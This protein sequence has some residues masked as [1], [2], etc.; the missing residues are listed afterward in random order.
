M[1]VF[2]NK[3]KTIFVNLFYKNKESLDYQ[4]KINSSFPKL[5]FDGFKIL[6][7]YIGYKIVDV[8]MYISQ[9]ERTTTL[10]FHLFHK[11]KG[12]ESVSIKCFSDIGSGNC[13]IEACVFL[14]EIS[15][16]KL[17]QIGESNNNNNN[18]NP[19]KPKLYIVR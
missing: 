2:F 6:K 8:D 13:D 18:N 4:A 7:T 14:P 10:I 12:P 19:V 5:D 15:I 16:E 17:R 3:I 1:S 9:E 11:K